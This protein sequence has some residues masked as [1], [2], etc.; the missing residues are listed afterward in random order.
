VA[1]SASG[2]GGGGEA[3]TGANVGSG[4]GIFR[5]KTGV[6][7]NFKSLTAGTGVTLTQSADEIEIAASGG[8]AAFPWPV[9]FVASDT[10]L[11]PADQGVIVQTGGII[12]LPASA[13]NGT[14]FRIYGSPGDVRINSN[15]NLIA[16]IG[17]GTDLRPGEPSLQLVAINVPSLIWATENRVFQSYWNS[18]RSYRSGEIVRDNNDNY[19]LSRNEANIQP[20]TNPA[21]W[22]PLSPRRVSGTIAFSDL[23]FTA[24]AAP[25]GLSYGAYTI[26]ECGDALLLTIILQLGGLS[27]N[28]TAVRIISPK[29][30]E[31]RDA[32]SNAYGGYDMME[33]I[34]GYGD[35]T[36]NGSFVSAQRADILYSPTNLE[37]IEARFNP[38]NGMIDVNMRV[39]GRR[40]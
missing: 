4:A 7:L 17:I 6:L 32:F 2:G 25:T 9:K 39:L 22:L 19:F 13:P 10:T 20:L 27:N 37:Y 18:S 16:G 12:T 3:N 30:W 8:G 34:L 28:V 33:D 40:G 29:V 36:P 15:G 23:A 35:V 11:T 26:S 31:I 21:A 24:T 1:Q 5:D 14:V 38:I